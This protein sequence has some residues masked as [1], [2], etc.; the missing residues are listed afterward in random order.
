MQSQSHTKSSY[1]SAESINPGT[2]SDQEVI[3]SCKWI[4]CNLVE[5][6]CQDVNPKAVYHICESLNAQLQIE[7]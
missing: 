3:V 2:D 1:G 7:L 6:A 4:S 5:V